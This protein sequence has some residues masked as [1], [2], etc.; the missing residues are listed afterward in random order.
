VIT[1]NTFAKSRGTAIR[2][3][4]V[5]LSRVIIQSPNTIY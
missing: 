4:S 1:G 2:V 5:P 3:V